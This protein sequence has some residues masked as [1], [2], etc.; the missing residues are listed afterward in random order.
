MKV[1]EEVEFRTNYQVKVWLAPKVTLAAETGFLRLVE[2]MPLLDKPFPKHKR[3]SDYAA[4]MDLVDAHF[5]KLAWGAETGR[6]DQDLELAVGDYILACK[7]NLEDLA[8]YNP[9]IIYFIVGQDLMHIENFMGITPKGGN[10]L[11]VDSRF[12]LLYE[13]AMET[14]IRSLYECRKVAP[15]E[16]L[17]IPGNHD[18]HASLHL[19]F[20]LREHFRKDK[21]VTIDV[22]PSQR[23]ARLFGNLLVGWTHEISSR[24]NSWANEL[25]QAFPE[26]WGPS[27]FREWHYGHKHKKKEVKTSPVLTEGGV[28]MRQMSALSQIDAW[29]FEN[30]FTDAVPGAEA[31]LWTK[32]RGIKANFTSLVRRKNDD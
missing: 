18:V 26:L 22:A 12:P 4:E 19:C 17:W 5:A 15:V 28:L 29:H 14:V 21:Q 1:N 30:L 13:K 20:A 6:P 7:E 11:D 16:V 3:S 10:I 31:F 25:A 32:D 9:E 2:K 24:E 23:K 27:V 8:P